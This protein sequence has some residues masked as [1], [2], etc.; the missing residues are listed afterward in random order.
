[1]P[2]AREQHG[3]D[4]VG[5]R[6]ERPFV[7]H[8]QRERRV[9]GVRIYRYTLCRWYS[10]TMS[11]NIKDERV[12]ALA[13]DAARVTG[14]NQTRAIEL[15]LERLLADAGASPVRAERDRRLVA[16]ARIGD[17]WAD[18]RPDAISEVDDLYDEDGLPARRVGR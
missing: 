3:S 2:A 15:A 10:Y 7:D 12:H 4:V 18:A 11:L 1:M 9:P 6:V 13:R 14:L 16:L 17:R 8:Q 5:G